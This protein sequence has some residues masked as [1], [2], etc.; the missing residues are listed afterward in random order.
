M[1]AGEQSVHPAYMPEPHT[2]FFE[3]E[4][5]K[6]MFILLSADF[7]YAM[8]IINDFKELTMVE[9]L[10]F[11]RCKNDG[12][13][14]I[15]AEKGDSFFLGLARIIV[16]VCSMK[17]HRTEVMH[18]FKEFAI[19][20]GCHISSIH[21]ISKLLR[22]AFNTVHKFHILVSAVETYKKKYPHA[23]N[24]ATG[25]NKTSGHALDMVSDDST[26]V[27]KCGHD[28]ESDSAAATPT[29]KSPF[30]SG[31]EFCRRKRLRREVPFWRQM[32]FSIAPKGVY[33]TKTNT[34]RV[35]LNVKDVGSKFSRNVGSLEDAL[36]LY[37]IKIL[38]SDRPKNIE[39]QVRAGNYA[40]LIIIGACCSP[41]DYYQ[42]I[43][44]KIFDYGQ[45]SYLLDI[46]VASAV[47]AFKECAHGPAE[48][49]NPDESL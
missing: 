24:L 42:K 36:W 25:A 30:K 1:I 49:L 45:K 40:S 4:P 29:D 47:S 20:S 31:P 8:A 11:C 22:E 10:P 26:S 18:S 19:K 9:F 35:Q 27:Q 23:C 5:D 17:E 37:E 38:A 6:E 13:F 32:G 28:T 44:Q 14:E 39:L 21:D 12:V 2:A 33:A 15:V 41:E 16:Y 46:E 34:F 48:F 3:G 43:Q 7:R